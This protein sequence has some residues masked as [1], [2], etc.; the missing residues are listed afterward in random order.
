MVEIWHALGENRP[1]LRKSLTF[2]VFHTR[3]SLWCLCWCMLHYWFFLNVL[4]AHI[5]MIKTVCA[6]TGVPRSIFS[7]IHSSFGFQLGII[8]QDFHDFSDILAKQ[9]NAL[10]NTIVDCS[11]SRAVLHA[12]QSL[13]ICQEPST[14]GRLG[15]LRTPDL[16][17]RAG[18]LSKVNLT[19]SLPSYQI[20]GSTAFKVFTDFKCQKQ[21]K[22]SD[23]MSHE[24]R[25]ICTAHFTS[26][27]RRM[28]RSLFV[29]LRK[30]SWAIVTW[31]NS[32]GV[33]GMNSV[34]SL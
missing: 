33:V 15:R 18:W 22:Q 13:E 34:A 24:L 21:R 26:T 6:T 7:N 31:I 25:K 17:W 10:F 14:P 9:R 11:W 8:Y 30:A 19:F 5:L 12:G 28:T 4:E 2:E 23:P 32:F 29:P 16:H 3:G 20:L 27:R 1:N